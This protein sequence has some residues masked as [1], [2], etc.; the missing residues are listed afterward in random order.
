MVDSTSHKILPGSHWSRIVAVRSWLCCQSLDGA[1]TW[2]RANIC[3]MT[4]FSLVE[5][6]SV[7]WILSYSLCGGLPLHTLISR[8]GRLE[9]VDVRNELSL[10]SLESLTN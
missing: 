8:I 6:P 7:H 9:V 1:S 5:A 10:R 3:K 2:L 4:P